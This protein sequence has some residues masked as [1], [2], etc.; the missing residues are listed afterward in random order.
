MPQWYNILVGV[1]LSRGDWR[2]NPEGETPSQ[3]ACERAIHL[4]QALDAHREDPAKL[5]F[6]AVL[7]LDEKTQRLIAKS[8]ADEETVVSS[9][10]E[11]LRHHVDAAA[12]AGIKADSEV[13]LGRPRVELLKYV[14]E[15]KPDIVLIG[16]RGHG[17]LGS[18]LVGSTAI[19]LIAQSPCPVGVIKQRPNPTVDRILLG[20]NFTPVCN[21]LLDLAIRLARLFKAELHV[22]HVVEPMK[23]PFL[24]FSAVSDDE[25]NAAYDEA[26][27]KARAKLDEIAAR[28]DA[29]ALSPK[30]VTHLEE[31]IASDVVF[32]Q[33]K[34][35]DIDVL[36]LGTVTQGGMSSMFFGS[37][38]QRL[39]PNLDCSLLT[40]RPAETA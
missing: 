19:S 35:L 30:M 3:F 39:L 38:A 6:V 1:D 34:E 17:M 12:K 7:D 32:R 28:E 11:A 26:V 18:I 22:T 33:T 20:T 27:S 40:M 29:A 37:T 24:Q 8:Q 13:L 25:V 16:N 36:M 9:A 31:G 21:R 2:A 10:E 5:H 15:T 23:R 14:N 4:A